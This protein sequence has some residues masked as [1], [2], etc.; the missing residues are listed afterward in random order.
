PYNPQYIWRRFGVILESAGMP[1]DR[2]H[3][4]HAIRKATASYMHAAGVDATAAM[5]HSSPDVTMRFYLDPR[6]TGGGK[7]PADVLPSLDEPKMADSKRHP[8]TERDTG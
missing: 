7:Q 5:G 8:G 1:N 6:I 4:F 2:K 3:K